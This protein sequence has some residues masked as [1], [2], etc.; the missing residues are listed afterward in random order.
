MCHFLLQRFSRPVEAGLKTLFITISEWQE[1]CRA[2]GSYIGDLINL[3]E[4]V[5]SY[6][7][8]Y[9]V[10][11]VAGV[12]IM[13]MISMLRYRANVHPLK[14]DVSRRKL[15]VVCGLVYL[16]SFI[17]SYGTYLPLCF[18]QW[19]DVAIVYDKVF[20]GY[21][22]SCFY[23]FPTIF[24][25][26][27]YYKICREL[28]KQN[29]YM[30]NVLR[31]FKSSETKCA[32]LFLQYPEICPKST[33]FPCLSHYRPML[34]KSNWKYSHDCVPYFKKHHWRKSFSN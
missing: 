22:V 12:G 5:Y 3:G 26:V 25:A 20:D 17:A 10:F 30:K 23:F 6:K 21:I 32:W 2:S 4:Q 18:M 8:I 34:R 24:M 16:V 28:I 13:L 31:M 29:R 19:N 9:L 27:V 1:K 15:K 11:L 7:H 14:P 33:N